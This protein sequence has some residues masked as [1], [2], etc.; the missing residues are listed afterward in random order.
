MLLPI[1]IAGQA[2]RAICLQHVR[3]GSVED[4]GK[5]GYLSAQ[6]IVI[7]AR[8]DVAGQFTADGAVACIGQQCGLIDT[9]G[10]FNAPTCSR[11][12]RSFPDLFSERLA[13]A[14]KGGQWRY[15][16]RAGRVLIPFKF[17]YAGPFDNGMA[18]VSENSRF[19]F[20]LTNR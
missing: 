8:F 16:D 11:Q 15:V 7:S 13:A 14:E 6:G 3:S 4:H 10:S 12:T 9:S 20:L 5:C 1:V 2:L 19:Y 18:R 17:R